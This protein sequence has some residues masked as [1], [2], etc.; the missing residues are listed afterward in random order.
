MNLA[1]PRVGG[2]A[3]KEQQGQRPPSLTFHVKY[4]RCQCIHRDSS[5][6]LGQRPAKVKDAG[7]HRVVFSAAVPR[8]ML[9]QLEMNN[10]DARTDSKPNESHPFA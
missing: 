8:A 7:A 4:D 9:E 5:R 10:H 3:I 1:R 6:G 2:T